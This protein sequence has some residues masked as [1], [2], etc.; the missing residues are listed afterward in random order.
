[1]SIRKRNKGYQIDISHAGKRHRF[2]IQGDQQDALIAEQ[3]CKK[4]LKEG[5]SIDKV[6]IS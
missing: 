1:M 2:N 6:I 4:G 5:K 3:Q